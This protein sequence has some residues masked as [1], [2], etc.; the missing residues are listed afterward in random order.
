MTLRYA[1][2]SRQADESREVR[3]DAD[4]H[5]EVPHL[6]VAEDRRPQVEPS[7]GEDDP[8][9]R[10]DESAGDDRAEGDGV[11]GVDEERHHGEARPP[12]DHVEP[13]ARRPGER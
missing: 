3:D 5:H 9:A 7:A 1:S 11:A 6:V 2:D 4:D 12:E 13:V 8:A 10:V